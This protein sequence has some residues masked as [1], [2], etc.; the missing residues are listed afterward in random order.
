M[1]FSSAARQIRQSFSTLVHLGEETS[2]GPRRR[3]SANRA[4]SQFLANVS[5]EL[6]T[7]LHA[8]L[9]GVEM[10][11]GTRTPADEFPNVERMREAIELI[12]NS[13]RR[14]LALVNELLD[15]SQIESGRL[16][17]DDATFDL[18][19]LLQRNAAM[20]RPLAVGRGLRFTLE[21]AADLPRFCSGR[22]V[23][24]RPSADEPLGNALKFTEVG[25]IELRAYVWPH[26]RR[27]S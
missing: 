17:I 6:R 27:C 25:E 24:D 19:D 23:A 10:A 12:D 21:Q 22:C 8:I 11:V 4:K 18:H 3:G 13:A 15:L 9:G 16:R 2:H 20:I 1:C 14:Q 7:P 5:H 26:G